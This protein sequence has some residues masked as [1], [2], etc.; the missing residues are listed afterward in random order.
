MKVLSSGKYNRMRGR[1]SFLMLAICFPAYASR[2][3]SANC[4][5]LLS[6]GGTSDLNGFAIAKVNRRTVWNH[7]SG[8]RIGPLT[9]SAV[10]PRYFADPAGRAVY[11]T[12]AHTWN[13]LVDMGSQLPPHSFNF[14]AYL[15]FLNAHHHNL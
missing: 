14:D 9:V 11:L 8:T 12:G 1:R 10:N 2:R 7:N 5:K 3:A 6:I 13:N 4:T 15:D